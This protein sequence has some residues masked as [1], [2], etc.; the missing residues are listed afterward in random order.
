MTGEAAREC[1]NKSTKVSEE[2]VE[3]YWGKKSILVSCIPMEQYWV[4]YHT[5]I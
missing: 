5:C 1:E 2:Q 3:K 4:I